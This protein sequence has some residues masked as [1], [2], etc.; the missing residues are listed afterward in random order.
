MKTP[1]LNA[2][3]RGLALAVAA[4][5]DAGLTVTHK[6][7]IAWAKRLRKQLAQAAKAPLWNETVQA[8]VDE[9]KG[10]GA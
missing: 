9:M 3:C 4:L 5:D 6:R 1:D 2:Q 8:A 7:V 10:G